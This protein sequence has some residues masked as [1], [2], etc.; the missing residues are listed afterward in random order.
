MKSFAITLAFILPFLTAC[1]SSSKNIKGSQNETRS[2]TSSSVNKHN[3]S[4]Y[5]YWVNN[6]SRAGYLTVTGSAKVQKRGGLRGQ[7][8]VAM[9][10]ARAEL[11]RVYHSHVESQSKTTIKSSKDSNSLHSDSS[12]RI[13]SSSALMLSD[14]VILDKWTDP[15]TK[16]LFIWLALP[17]KRN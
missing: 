12:T 7:Q 3:S 17:L 6:P 9:L 5:P 1:G 15:E 11:S 14:A 13:K 16:E 10:T 4:R 8:R 2:S